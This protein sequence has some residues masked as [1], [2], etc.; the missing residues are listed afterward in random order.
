MKK[1]IFCLLVT[2]FGFSAEARLP[3]EN[4]QRE[5]Q[6][7]YVHTS[8]SVTD[9]QSVLWF[10][11]K[12]PKNEAY[13]ILWEKTPCSEIPPAYPPDLFYGETLLPEETLFLVQH[14]LDALETTELWKYYVTLDTSTNDSEP[15]PRPSFLDTV[16]TVENCAGLFYEA[17]SFVNSLTD[18]RSYPLLYVQ[19]VSGMGTQYQ[20][21][22]SSSRQDDHENQFSYCQNNLYAG[23]TIG[24]SEI[25]LSPYYDIPAY[26]GYAWAYK[27]WSS[28]AEWEAFY[29]DFFNETS[30]PPDPDRLWFTQFT[31]GNRFQ[32]RQPAFDGLKYSEAKIFLQIDKSADDGV[33]PDRLGWADMNKLLEYGT[34]S[35]PEERTDEIFTTAVT[36]VPACPDPMEDELDRFWNW[37]L[38]RDK[39]Y[40]LVTMDYKPVSDAL[41]GC[42][43]C[44]K[45][46]GGVSTSLNS[47]HI[48][49]G[50]GTTANGDLAGVLELGA[51][52]SGLDVILPENIKRQQFP[53]TIPDTWYGNV[54]EVVA[55]QCIVHLQEYENFPFSGTL[56]TVHTR[57]NTSTD[58]AVQS[59]V[60]IAMHQN[61]TD[62]EDP[63]YV[64]EYDSMGNQQK[65]TIFSPDGSGDWAK[66]VFQSGD[67]VSES[68][69]TFSAGVTNRIIRTKSDPLYGEV[70]RTVETYIDF[71][72]GRE[73]TESRSGSES[74]GLWTAYTY[75]TN[76]VNTNSYSQIKSVLH[77][78]NS[79][80]RYE[81]DAA[82]DLYKTITPFGDSLPN[83]AESLCRVRTMSVTQ[84]GAEQTVTD[85]ETV[86]GVEVSRNYTVRTANET[87]T[88]R[89]ATAGAGISDS[90]NLVTT[91]TYEQDP[92]DNSPFTGKRVVKIEHADGTL[93]LKTY[94]DQYSETTWHGAPNN[95]GSSVLDGTRTEII[96][97][98]FGYVISR[99]AYDI[100]SGI[101]LN[102]EV[103]TDVY[104][105][106]RP[107]EWQ[108]LDGTTRDIE[109]GCCGLDRET[110][111]D[112]STRFF[113]YDPAGRQT[114]VSYENA[115]GSNVTERASYDAAGQLRKRGWRDNSTDRWVE[116]FAFDTAGRSTSGEKESGKGVGPIK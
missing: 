88:I 71:E 110:A 100:A 78:D 103:V 16:C 7:R 58:Y 93:T 61:A 40:A 114:E 83:A 51:E 48:Q 25:D 23:T 94:P 80:E 79:W 27:H 87:R 55:P 81:Y 111:R 28:S 9:D 11:A 5:M 12:I 98:D 20:L 33:Y 54:R 31:I 108:Y 26:S 70:E 97:N 18:I 106:G 41:G 59:Y 89:C 73:L 32:I 65:H 107:V 2:G 115:E 56:L 82:G 1:L 14:L 52:R 102:S 99:K 49:I 68:I 77:S 66:T 85:I 10:I 15:V 6:V 13:R 69:E 50:L 21:I 29:E 109:I 30:Q 45:T 91:T 60:W 8:Q 84:A 75:Y 22:P 64:F 86:L 38:N 92:N 67:E 34:L 3:I 72:W 116:C 113:E 101:L 53:G 112:G 46:P 104:G 4:L 24:N 37:N 43:S 35:S 42:A 76:A 63:V 62:S 44:L 74:N 90:G 96:R 57:E 36:N 39:T 17:H 47:L 95:N 105:D 19:G